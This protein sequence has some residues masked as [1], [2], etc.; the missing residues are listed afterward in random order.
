MSFG[1]KPWVVNVKSFIARPKDLPAPCQRE[2][3]GYDEEKVL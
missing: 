2:S 1:K 3:E